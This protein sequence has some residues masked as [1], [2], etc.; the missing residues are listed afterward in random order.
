MWEE[1]RLQVVAKGLDALDQVARPAIAPL[2]R[3]LDVG[4]MGKAVL[5]ALESMGMDSPFKL[6]DGTVVHPGG[7]G[8]LNLDMVQE[9]ENDFHIR[10]TI[11]FADLNQAAGLRPDGK[12][13]VVSMKPDTVS[14]AEVQCILHMSLDARLIKVAGLP[15]FRHH[16]DVKELTMVSPS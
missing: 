10:M 15:Q 3:L 5:R 4:E 6:D 13:V 12:K 14:W 1:E 11:T 7:E 16:F 9:T 2:T 8:V